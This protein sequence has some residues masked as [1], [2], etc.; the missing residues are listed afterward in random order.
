VRIQTAPPEHFPWIA[1]RAQLVISPN[2][3]ACEAVDDSGRIHGMIGF[4]GFMPGSVAMSIALDNPAAFRH[5]I[6]PA[7]FFA[8]NEAK[9]PLA[10]CTVLSSNARSLK[11]VRK[12]GFQ[13]VW[14]ARNWW[15]PDVDLV[16]FE[17]KRAACRWIQPAQPRRHR[18]AA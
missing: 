10:T 1:E 9:K 18:W 13:E 16:F 6:G 5:L 4:D 14:R 11:L 12:V 15:A 3:V 7:F 8:F 2:F 17:M